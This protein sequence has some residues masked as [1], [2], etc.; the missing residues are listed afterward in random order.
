M[1][2]YTKC[3]VINDFLLA[4]VHKDALIFPLMRAPSAALSLRD[5][6]WAAVR[7]FFIFFWGGG[8][9]SPAGHSVHLCSPTA[10]R[11]VEEGAL[12]DSYKHSLLQG[13]EILWFC[14]LVFLF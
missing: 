11:W 6:P 12:A 2:E 14:Y 8:G 13:Q 3:L 4:T 1:A 10:L 7:G 5:L 9:R